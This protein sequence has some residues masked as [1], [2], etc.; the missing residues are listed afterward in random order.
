MSLRHPLF[1]DYWAS[2]NADLSKITVPAFIVASW[3]DQGLHTRGTL[4]GFRQIASKEKWLMVHGKKKW[5]VFHEQE[6]LERQ[7]QFFDKF[8]KGIDSEIKNWPR[9]M[10]E[11]RRRYGVGNFRN[12][13][14]W[15][16]ARTQYTKLY[17]N[18]SDGKMSSSPFEK[19][20]QAR[21]IV[22]DIGDKTQN[23]RFEF[24]F[25]KRTEL[26]G[27]HETETLGTSGW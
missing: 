12:E 19:E 3:S 24:E 26:T 9:V 11:I 23:A 15:P 14:E 13:S 5:N 7:R 10:L 8:L 25:D 16:L 4:E 2:K 21:Y 27:L 20:A 22:S 18:G 17:L 1:D 6:N